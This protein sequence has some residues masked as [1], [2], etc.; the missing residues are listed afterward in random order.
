MQRSIGEL[1]LTGIDG[2]G[3]VY[4]KPVVKDFNEDFNEDFSKDF[5]NVI[6]I[7]DLTPEEIQEDWTVRVNGECLDIP[8]Y[9][10]KGRELPESSDKERPEVRK[11][12]ILDRLH[13]KGN[14]DDPTYMRVKAD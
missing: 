1:S 3:P 8:T 6:K 14:L 11:R 2:M 13:F 10:R 12:G 7:R 5:S 4:E 9:Q